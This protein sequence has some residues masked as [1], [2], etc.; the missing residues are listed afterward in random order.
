[1][2]VTEPSFSNWPVQVRTP[3][4]GP[5]YAGRAAAGGGAGLTGP[6]RGGGGATC[7]GGAG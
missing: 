2:I 7:C 1:L 6:G 4:V 3:D 5:L